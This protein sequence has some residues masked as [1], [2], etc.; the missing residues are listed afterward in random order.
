MRWERA[1]R[2]DRTTF[3]PVA[4]DTSDTV[5]D[6]VPGSDPATNTTRYDTKDVI[7]YVVTLCAVALV[8][9]L[10]AKLAVQRALGV[11]FV[12]GWFA[13]DL[14]WSPESKFVRFLNLL[15]YA[16]LLAR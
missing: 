16:S 2:P 7:A 9:S 5:P 13:L 10:A 8:G 11:Q 6:T 12:V 14:C 1:W 3:E 15:D 4:S